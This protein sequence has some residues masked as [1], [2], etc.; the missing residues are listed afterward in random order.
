ML[1]YVDNTLG[2]YKSGFRNVPSN[3]GY[4]AFATTD[5][6]LLCRLISSWHVSCRQSGR[7]SC[8]YCGWRGLKDWQQPLIPSSLAFRMQCTP[9]MGVR[10]S[11]FDGSWQTV[12]L[13]TCGDLNLFIAK[14]LRDSLYG[15]AIEVGRFCSIRVVKGSSAY[16]AAC[17]VQVLKGGNSSKQN[18]QSNPRVCLSEY[19]FRWCGYGKY[20]SLNKPADIAW[21]SLQK[22]SMATYG[23]ADDGWNTLFQE[24]VRIRS[25]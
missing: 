12:S 16:R 18:E 9:T 20:P 1:K 22:L 8:L 5:I 17:I 2:W 19:P 24:R 7:P 15:D 23:I 3:Q 6:D 13:N 25:L 11:H 10:L 4:S 14:S 21:H